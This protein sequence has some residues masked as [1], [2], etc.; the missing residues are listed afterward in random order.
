MPHWSEFLNNILKA[1]TQA[2]ESVGKSMVYL[3]FGICLALFVAIG[4]ASFR[5]KRNQTTDYLLANRDLSPSFVG[6]SAVASWCSGFMFMGQ[7]GFTYTRGLSSIWIMLGLIAGDLFVSQLTHK[8][9]RKRS[10]KN[11]QESYIET[12]WDNTHEHSYEVVKRF[13]AAFT[14]IALMGYAAAQVLSSGLALQALID[15][16]YQWGATLTTFL[17]VL[18]CFVGGLRAS[19]WTDVAQALVM[20]LSMLLLFSVALYEMGGP[21][22]FFSRL[23]GVSSEFTSLYPP[24]IY[25]QNALFLGLIFLGWFA[26]GMGVAGQP[27]I[28]IRFMALKKPEL[29]NR[30]RVYY[31]AY[32]IALYIL[33]ILIGLSAR[34]LLP[35]LDSSQI[36]M[37]LPLMSKMLL[38]EFFVGL[39][40]AGLFASTMSTA[41]SLLLSAS[42]TFTRNLIPSLQD[43]YILVKLTT[44]F[45]SMTALA[46]A[47][48]FQTTVFNM[49]VIFGGLLSACFAPVLILRSFGLS[50]NPQQV[51]LMVL[52]SAITTTAWRI[53]GQSSLIYEVAIGMGVG[54]LLGFVLIRRRQ[55]QN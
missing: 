21:T 47:I 52:T 5:K 38:P 41:D 53:A 34:V 1:C 42:G 12:L 33:A 11:N 31:Y 54:L 18:Y 20:L 30:A 35:S 17:I 43:R 6:L 55:K 46:L 4:L 23:Q 48:F 37:A 22:E 7:I 9:L 14:I 44:L 26:G 24:D 16:P 8:K 40:L 50:L 2:G 25:S 10:E 3:S 36:E 15:I 51:F 39:I 19:I 45:L 49:V 32:Y 28:M 13:V 29:V 27:H